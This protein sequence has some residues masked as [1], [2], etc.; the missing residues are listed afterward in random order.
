VLT[1]TER[2]LSEEERSK[3]G[4][5]LSD[6]RAE[7][8]RALVKAGLSG[9]VVCGV[10]AVLT[11]L[12]SDAPRP[13]VVAFWSALWLMFTLWIGLPWRK[14][15]LEQVRFF[16][17]AL[18]TNRVREIRLQASRVVEFEEEEDEGACYAFD[19]DGNSAVFVVGQEFY[20]GDD[21]PNS[22]FSVLEFLGDR[23]QAVDVEIVKR[24]RK[25]MPERVIPA[26][27]KNQ[28]ELPEH[29]TVVPSAL[30]RIEMALPRRVS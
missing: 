18:R 17:E 9:A 25:L 1:Q 11:L 28:L 20:E 24:G 19:H 15:M 3:L 4:A 8:W 26:T 10:L 16:E 12:A 30:D 7:S 21:F 27:V 5:R 2:P 13:L 6:A 29:L 22:D 14:Q 23:G